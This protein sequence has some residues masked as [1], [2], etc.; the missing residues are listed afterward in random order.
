MSARWRRSLAIWAAWLPVVA[1]GEWVGRLVVG[2]DLDVAVAAGEPQVGVEGLHGVEAEAGLQPGLVAQHDAPVAGCRRSPAWPGPRSSG[3]SARCRRRPCCR[4]LE[5]AAATGSGWARA[6]WARWSTRCRTCPCSVP[7]HRAP[8]ASR[9]AAG[10]VVE[11]LAVRR[12]GSRG[13][14]RRSGASRARPDR[15]DGDRGQGV[16]ARGPAGEVAQHLADDAFLGGGE[17]RRLGSRR[18][19][20]PGASHRLKVTVA[21]RCCLGAVLPRP[22]RRPGAR[23]RVG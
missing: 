16:C 5:G 19:R 10:A 9:S 14:G 7:S 4:L 18:G 21:R 11:V 1:G 12:S 13:P 23:G 15:G 6:S 8:R 3:T 2:D 20:G 22:S 17:R